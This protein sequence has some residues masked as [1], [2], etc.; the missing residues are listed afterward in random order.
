[1]LNKGNLFTNNILNFFSSYIK[2]LI[3]KKKSNKPKL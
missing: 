1:M 3:A 2:L